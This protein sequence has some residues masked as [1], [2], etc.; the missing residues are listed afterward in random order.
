MTG[1]IAMV[2]NQERR[3]ARETCPNCSMSTKMRNHFPII[4]MV[5]IRENPCLRAGHFVVLEI[6]RKHFGR[7]A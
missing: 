7:Q 2:A 5:R 6:R 3:S 1:T 4:S